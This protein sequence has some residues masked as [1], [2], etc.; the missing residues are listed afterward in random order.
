MLDGRGALAAHDR[1]VFALRP[2][3]CAVMLDFSPARLT[4]QQCHGGVGKVGA[5]PTPWHKFSFI[6]SKRSVPQ[7]T[8]SPTIH[9]A[10]KENTMAL[11]LTDLDERVNGNIATPTTTTTDQAAAIA[12]AIAPEPTLLY[13]ERMR[14]LRLSGWLQRRKKPL[15]TSVWRTLQ[16]KSDRPRLPRYLSAHKN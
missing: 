1:R 16:R 7:P 11:N 4:A 3:S 9:T 10:P 12:A 5:K 8:A 13:S 14:G 6:Q 2:Q 15:R